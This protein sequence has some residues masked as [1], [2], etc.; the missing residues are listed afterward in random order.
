MTVG[1]EREREVYS[2]LRRL[3]EV[4][5]SN[6]GLLE[7]LP[8]VGDLADAIGPPAGAFE[9]DRRLEQLVRRG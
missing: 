3:R 4:Q 5:L 7:V 9:D 8:L 2:L 6:A 1:R